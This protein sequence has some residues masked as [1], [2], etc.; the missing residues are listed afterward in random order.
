M[1]NSNRGLVKGVAR[2]PEI[3]PEDIA[4]MLT[5]NVSGLVAMTQAILP[6][7]LKRAPNAN[8]ISG[9]GDIV[10]IGSVAGRVP[11]AGGSIYCAS[12]AAVKSFSTSLRKELVNT[13]V[14]VIEVDPGMV[15]TEFSVVRFYGDKNKADD[16]YK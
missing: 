11:Y 1:L 5:T 2:A 14:R 10:N 4:T 12:K 3:K 16:V 6:I 8:G 7:F 13:G 15:E 9:K